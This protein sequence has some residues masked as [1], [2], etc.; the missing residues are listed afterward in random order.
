MFSEADGLSGL[1]VDRYDQ[2]LVMQFTALGLAERRQRLAELLADLLRPRGIILRTERGVGKLEGLELQ[3]GPLWG[4]APSEPVI[5]EENGVK[6]LVHLAEGQKTGFYLD[7]RD[8]RA[9]VARLAVGRRVLDGFC[10][11]GGFGLYAARAGA[12][13]V[14]GVDVS[15]PAPAWRGATRS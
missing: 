5:V 4:E 6:F 3:D 1:T 9:A 14:L 8:N 11:T 10:Y 12:R 7:Q 2:Q 13:E 15:E